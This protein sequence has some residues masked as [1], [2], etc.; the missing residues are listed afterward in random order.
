QID[1]GGTAE[2]RLAAVQSLAEQHTA[3]GTVD[4][5]ALAAS[6]A[7]QLGTPLVLQLG[8]AITKGASA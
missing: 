3:G 4:V 7:A 2:A 1:N 5:E 6:L 8:A